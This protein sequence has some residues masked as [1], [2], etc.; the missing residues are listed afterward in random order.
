MLL[1]QVLLS[2]LLYWLIFVSTADEI[3]ISS[4]ATCET[5][6]PHQHHFQSLVDA[7]KQVTSNTVIKIADIKYT[8]AG[9]A[10][11]DEIENVTLTGNGKSKTEITCSMKNETIRAGIIF[12]NST[13]ICLKDFTI[14]NC[15]LTIANSVSNHVGRAT[16]I[17]IINCSQV[18]VSSILVSN[19][20]QGLTF[21]DTQS[22]VHV[23]DSQFTNNTIQD[24]KNWPGGGGLQILFM[25][26]NQ[27]NGANYSILRNKF[28][29]NAATSQKAEVYHYAGKGG[30]IRI[31]LFN[32]CKN[33]QME[34]D[35]NVIEGNRA[36]FG[37]GMLVILSG[38]ASHNNI[39]ISSNRFVRNAALSGG[40]GGA[41]VGFSLYNHGIYQN[42]SL[43]PLLN[44]VAI[45]N[46]TFLS[47][48]A[49]TFGGGVL[50]YAASITFN[51]K[52]LLNNFVCTNCHFENNT[53]QNGA[54]LSVNVNAFIITGAQYILS[55][56]FSDCSFEQNLVHNYQQKGFGAV[57][58]SLIPVTF[59]GATVFIS[60]TGTA[61]YMA[62]VSVTFNDNSQVIFASNSGYH[63]GGIHMFGHS[64][65]HVCNN[66]YLKFQNNTATLYGGAL[67]IQSNQVNIFSFVDMCFLRVSVLE[68][69]NITFSFQGNTAQ[70]GSD[71][72][73][74]TLAPCTA[75]CEYRSNSA[76][77]TNF[78]YFLWK[79][80]LGNFS[81]SNSSDNL[82][83]N[84]A[85][86]PE[87]ITIT[88]DS[89]LIK[90]TPGVLST[91]N[92]TQTDELGANVS[93]F[94]SLSAKIEKYD[95]CITVHPDYTIVEKNKIILQGNPKARGKLLLESQ[96][97][98]VGIFD[99]QL[100]D[101]PPGFILV[102]PGCNAE[103]TCFALISNISTSYYNLQCTPNGRVQ[104]EYKH[105]AGY[106]N[107]SDPS[108]ETLF[109]GDCIL[110]LCN[111]HH[112]KFMTLPE[113]PAQLEVM[114]CGENRTGY[115]CGKCKDNMSVYYHSISYTCGDS[116]NCKFGIPLYI[117][118]ELLPVTIFFL[119]NNTTVQHQ[120]HIWSFV[121]ICFLCTG[122]FCV[123]PYCF[124]LNSN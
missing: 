64:E 119:L 103:C 8:L 6:E 33:I 86:S 38:N 65:L 36:M 24:H 21:I 70:L 93:N 48:R 42:E 41:E 12:K 9:V 32:K 11:F 23:M 3:I 26:M 88:G 73:A 5:T 118:S 92:I 99:F 105:W 57:Y 124:W 112:H 97:A 47:N 94:F 56:T 117:V 122:P 15:S 43:H 63:G 7:A 69:S 87:N 121:W 52:L 90:L 46:A 109:T 96:S 102:N 72:Y 101:C 29:Y 95:Q 16:A 68:S 91:L 81:F 80:C 28:D 53:A 98:A 89:Q 74:T 35:S 115:L 14:T 30:G 25:H 113:L 61:L 58:A 20:S 10:R 49:A 39:H 78:P 106:A 51:A 66:S 55:V 82:T 71:M 120:P 17:Q 60:N 13:G 37:G 75:L 85:T 84:V 45:F 44:N 18:V 104:I 110:E 79:S 116:T 62:S 22:S 111:F 108:Q 1:Q 40:G 19:S 123:I 50:L 114:I 2:F 27:N 100:N 4:N 77:V 67:S 83:N 76:L 54:A 107:T 34:L 31:L 59:N